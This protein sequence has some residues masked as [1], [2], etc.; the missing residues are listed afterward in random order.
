MSSVIL[1][2]KLLSPLTLFFS[3]FE[4]FCFL[5]VCGVKFSSPYALGVQGDCELVID[6]IPYMYALYFANFLKFMDVPFAQLE[7]YLRSNDMVMS[8]ASYKMLVGAYFLDFLTISFIAYN[9]SSLF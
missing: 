8:R 7:F 6:P 2:L 1:S 4:D 5:H 9:S 3:V